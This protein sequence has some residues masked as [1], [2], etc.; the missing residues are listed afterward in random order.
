MYTVYSLTN[1]NTDPRRAW[2]RDTDAAPFPT[3]EQMSELRKHA[4]LKRGKVLLPQ[5][6]L[7]IEMP[8]PSVKLVHACYPH[9]AAASSRLT[10]QPTRQDC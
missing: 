9:P 2:K 7:T 8:Y 5:N 3:A 1:A 10:A 6:E 4:S